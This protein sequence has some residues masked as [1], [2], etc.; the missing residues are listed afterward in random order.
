MRACFLINPFLR[1][2][3][4]I[5]VVVVRF[6]HQAGSTRAVNGRSNPARTHTVQTRATTHHT[7]QFRH[8]AVTCVRTVVIIERAAR[9]GQGRMMQGTAASYR[10]PGP[11]VPNPNTH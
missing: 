1:L 2:P 3:I 7:G 11:P 9:E 6:R 4:I 5:I 8:R 10:T